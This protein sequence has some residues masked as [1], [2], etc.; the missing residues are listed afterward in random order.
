M[1]LNEIFFWICPEPAWFVFRPRGQG[2]RDPGLVK[3]GQ[4][5]LQMSTLADISLDGVTLQ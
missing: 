1:W 2:V 5:A 4:E 3:L